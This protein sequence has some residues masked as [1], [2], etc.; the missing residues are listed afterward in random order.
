MRTTV[1]D[2]YQ[3][4]Y[5]VILARDCIDSYDPEHHEISLKYMDGHLGRGMSNDE[6]RSMV[7]DV[8]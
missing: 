5:E 7:I 3:R 4:D 2:A 8:V 6:L 1:V